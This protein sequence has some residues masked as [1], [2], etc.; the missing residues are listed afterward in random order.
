M[1]TSKY[2][3]GLIFFPAFDWAISPDHPEREERLLYTRDQIVEEGL[4]DVPG[5]EEHRPQIAEDASINRIHVCV[6]NVSRIITESH[7]IAV[8]GTIV[9]SDLVLTGK[10]DRAFALLRPPGHHAMRIVHGS[11]G[12]CLVNNEAIMVEHIRHNYGPDTRIAIIDT[13]AHHGDGTQDIFYN[14]PG[15]LHIS[16]HQDGRTLYPGTGFIEE[17]GGP[18]AFGL[19]VNVPLPPGTGDKGILYVLENL[20]L[21]VLEDFEPD[22]VINAAG[23]D[24]HYTDPLTNMNFTARGYA[25]LTE[26]LSPDIVV[27]EGGYSIEG[28]LPYINAG[29]LLA[30]A[31]LDYSATKEPD[32]SH[33]LTKQPD[34]I[35]QNIDRL[36]DVLKDM[37][38]TRESVDLDKVFGTSPVFE[39]KRRIYYDTD[40]ISE[41]Q[42]ERITKCKLCAGWRLIVSSA[43][44]NTGKTSHIAAIII[45]W[46]ACQTC[47]RAAEKE[48]AKACKDPRLDHVYLQDTERDRFLHT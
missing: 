11:R 24:N 19:T 48:F 22:I 25:R 27:L 2:K 7:R 15:I 5:I 40:G 13:D 41:E 38:N 33:R 28:A 1:E 36:V 16:L 23:Q 30:L 39:R 10:T 9:A 46:H 8:G 44:H 14:D 43:T 18:K 21:P 17:R 12:F 47:K 34:E 6:P 35:T 45:P 42:S 26:L 3:V 29:I 37:W 32:W 4:L 31:G 20:V